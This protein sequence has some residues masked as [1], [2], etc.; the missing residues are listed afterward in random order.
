MKESLS[1]DITLCKEYKKKLY[2]IGEVARMIGVEQSVLRFWEEKFC[3][4]N[5]IKRRGR[6]LYDQNNIELIKKVKYLLYDSG[7]TVKGVQRKLK[8]LNDG[9][10]MIYEKQV[11]LTL[12][13]DMIKL[14]DSLLKKI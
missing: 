1:D 2:T 14:R 3:Q 10:N 11:L 13:R 7:Y 6:R 12:L 5:P 9:E 8:T 4:I